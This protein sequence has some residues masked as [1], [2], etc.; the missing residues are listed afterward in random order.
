MS[1]QISQVSIVPKMSSPFSALSLRPLDATENPADLRAG[2]IRIDIVRPVLSRTIHE[3]LGLER[4]GDRCGLAGLPDDGVAHRTA[5]LLV[6]DH[7]RLALVRDADAGDVARD[8]TGL[9]ESSS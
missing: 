5:R 7:G 4:L 3:P 6:P 8:K 1:F 9:L 2:E